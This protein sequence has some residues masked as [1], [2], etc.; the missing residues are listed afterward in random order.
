MSTSPMRHILHIDMDA[1]FAAVEQRDHPELR[2][3]PVLVGGSPTRRGVVSTASY[4]ARKYGC[5]SAMPMATAVRLCPHAVVISSGMG[6]YSQVS[7]QILEIMERF[8]PL[9][10]PVSIDEAFLDITGCEKL[11]GSPIEIAKKIKKLI[12]KE[13]QLTASVGLAPNKFLAKIASDLKKPDGLVVVPPH[14]IQEFLDPLPVSRLWGAGKATLPKFE[15]LHL[16]TFADIRKLPL[17]EMQ[18]HF[19]SAGEMFYDFVRGIDNRTICTES[20]TKS[21][22]TETTF[23]VDVKDLDHLRSVLLEQTDQIAGRLRRHQLL[24]RTVT[25]KLR[26]P[27]FATITRSETLNSPTDRT[28]ELWNT[29]SGLFEIWANRQPFAV[30]LIG[31]GLSS[32]V[33]YQGRQL[34]LFDREENERKQHLDQTV[35]QIRSKFGFD[36]ITRGL[37]STDGKKKEENQ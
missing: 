28:D 24:A 12:Y 9:I 5:H 18:R 30:R 10:E 21:I 1:F 7:R 8:T 35:D 4:E 29:V 3:K 16:Y 2:G 34:M 22:S 20:E 13:T 32:L 26:R 36:A 6:R 23:P 31:A 33:P 15:K 27:D 14:R 17:S 11:F 37:T 19:G 25:I